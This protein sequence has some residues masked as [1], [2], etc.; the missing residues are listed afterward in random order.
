MDW[1]LDIGINFWVLFKGIVC[2]GEVGLNLIEWIVKYGSVVV[3]GYD[4][5]IMDGMNEVG[6]VVNVLWLVE[7][8]YLKY[9]GSQLGF[10]ILLWV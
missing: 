4:V 10:V 5:V 1:W 7:L 3:M 9:D 2:I 6:L 8:E